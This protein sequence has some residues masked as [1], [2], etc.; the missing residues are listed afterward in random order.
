MY[1]LLTALLLILPTS[2]YPQT[3]QE[4]G[5][6][7]AVEADKRDS[8]WQDSTANMRMILAN[9]QG[10]TSERAIRIKSKETAGQDNGDKSLTVFDSPKDIRGT[11]FLSYSHI[12]SADDQWLYLPALKRVKRISSANKSGPFNGH[13]PNP[14]LQTGLAF[15]FQR[16][17]DPF[18]LIHFFKV[19]QK[20]LLPALPQSPKQ[21]IGTIVT[22]GRK[23]IGLFFILPK[24]IFL[25]LF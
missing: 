2:V 19:L 6:A 11:A 23:S 7:I 12:V 9:K 18:E 17:H 15:P 14:I 24:I 5:L 22:Q 1:K 10:E 25:N 16:V 3:P 20:F 4:K 8:G 13:Y 21:K